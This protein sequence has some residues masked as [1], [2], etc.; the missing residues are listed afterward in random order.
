KCRTRPRADAEQGGEAHARGTALRRVAVHVEAIARILRSRRNGK[1]AVAGQ[2]RSG[3][4]AECRIDGADD[5]AN[6][7]SGSDVDTR[8]LADI[9]V[10]VFQRERHRAGREATRIAGLKTGGRDR[11]RAGAE[12]VVEAEELREAGPTTVRRRGGIVL[13]HDTIAPG[14]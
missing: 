8:L 2:R 11:R 1:A 6:R 14:G 12:D 13:N 4:P 9:A 7:H 3:G 5:V 10:A